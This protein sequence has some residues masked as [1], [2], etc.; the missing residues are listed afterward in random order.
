MSPLPPPRKMPP[1]TDSPVSEERKVKLAVPVALTRGME[2]MLIEKV[3][4]PLG[5]VDE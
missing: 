5:M 3:R 2:V 4:A 1:R